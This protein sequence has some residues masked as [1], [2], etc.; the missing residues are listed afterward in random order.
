MPK[1]QRNPRHKEDKFRRL[2]GVRRETFD[3]MLE[4]L[5]EAHARKKSRGGAPNKLGVEQMLRMML[6][7][8]REYR[9]YLHVGANYG[10]SETTAY[11][12]IRWAEETLVRDGA[13]SLPGKKAL[14]KSDMEFETVLVDAT[15]T[16]VQRPKKNSAGGIPARKS[17]TP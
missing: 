16:P 4:I 6:E 3:K 5:R 10:V 11:N 1:K 13:F 8:L 9:T 7:Y 15:E 12:T 17:A 2:T 14:L